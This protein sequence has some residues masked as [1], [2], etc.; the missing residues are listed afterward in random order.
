M[1]LFCSFLV[2]LFLFHL[3]VCFDF[4]L[5]WVNCKAVDGVD[6]DGRGGGRILKE[7]REGNHNQSIFS[8]KLYF[9]ETGGVKVN[10]IQSNWT[11][12]YGEWEIWCVLFL[13]CKVAIIK[14][15]QKVNSPKY[16]KNVFEIKVTKFDLIGKMY[17][18]L[19][20]YYLVSWYAL[21]NNEQYCI[22]HVT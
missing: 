6:C 10:F 3:D 8:K 16:N 13:T 11:L 14:Q 22:K 17:L 20:S 21:S 9:Q 15:M 4:I 12:N 5:Q 7:V 2:C 19:G 18:P 1:C